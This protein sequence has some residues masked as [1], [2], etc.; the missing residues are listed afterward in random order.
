M[1]LPRVDGS[2]GERELR[3][4]TC[5]TRYYLYGVV[6]GVACLRSRGLLPLHSGLREVWPSMM[7]PLTCHH[8]LELL[9]NRSNTQS[10]RSPISLSGVPSIE[11]T[12]YARGIRLS[13]HRHRLFSSTLSLLARLGKILRSDHPQLVV[14]P[15]RRRA[16]W[17]DCSCCG[18]S[19]AVSALSWL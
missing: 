1:L 14:P 19:P 3:E 10:I 15:S 17:H 6:L 4:S 5:P 12:H 18:S 8:S 7:D 9:D 16:F 2:E 13:E 11:R